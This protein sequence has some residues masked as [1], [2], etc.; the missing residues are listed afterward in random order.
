M[1]APLA[2]RYGWDSPSD[3]YS[4]S[5]LL[6]KIGALGQALG[7]GR[8]LDIGAGNGSAL[9]A[10][11]RLGWTVCAIEPDSDG[12]GLAKKVEGVE[13]RNLGVGATLPAKWTNSFDLAISL[14]VVEHLFDPNL[15]VHTCSEALRPG[16]HALISTPY[17]GYWKNLAIA[18]ADKWDFHH[19]P[20][21]VGGHI[22]F[23]SRA[24][25]RRLFEK[26]GFQPISFHGAGRL[27]FLWKSMIW[28][29]QKPL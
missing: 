27:P 10:W 14:E 17:H 11:Q 20:E 6:T 25:L 29:F 19:H 5:Y 9:P 22:K 3:T 26:E 28:V 2:S 16:G 24:T 7:G 12:F 18:L 1:T 23:W 15:L 4:H 21:R 8:V 13:V